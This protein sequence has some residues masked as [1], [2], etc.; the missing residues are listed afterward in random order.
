MARYELKP[1]VVYAFYYDE[2]QLINIIQD[3]SIKNDYLLRDIISVNFKGLHTLLS[4]QYVNSTISFRWES[5]DW[6]GRFLIIDIPIGEKVVTYR[7]KNGF[8]LSYIE[9]KDRSDKDIKFQ[10]IPSD[11]FLNSY[12]I[13]ND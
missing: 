1:P 9:A 4:N 5:T 6:E 10:L 13:S 7:I 11:Q 12:K 2:E 3:T 8:F